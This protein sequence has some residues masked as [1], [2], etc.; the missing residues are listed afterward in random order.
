MAR[1][2]IVNLSSVSN[3]STGL[4]TVA[5]NVVPH[6]N[7]FRPLVLARESQVAGWRLAMPDSTVEGIPD[8]L[9]SDSGRLGHA[10]RLVWVERDLARLVRSTGGMLFSPVPEAPILKPVPSVVMVY[11]FIAMHCFPVVHPLHQYTKHYVPRVIRQARSSVCISSATSRDVVDRVDGHGDLATIT[12]GVDHQRFRPQGLDARKRFLYVGRYKDYKNVDMAVRAFA[13]LRRD[14][15][16]FWLAGPPDPGFARLAETKTVRE[17]QIRY[18]GQPTD[19][20][21]P[22]LM[23]SS[24]GL[25]MV[26]RSEGFGLPVLEAMASGTAVITSN[27]S[28]MPEAGGDAALMVD[29]ADEVATATAMTRLADDHDFRADR[30]SAG[31]RHAARFTWESAGRQLV[32]LIE[33]KIS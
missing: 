13:S 17:G 15:L 7:V 9:S 8:G 10:R 33:H 1:R 30:V 28:A 11:D 31:I 26:S 32:E 6:L 21:L 18:I 16:E 20:E 19:D 25:V 12:L 27:V 29:P 23:E 4:A 24:L 5:R 22:G 2:L 3:G 14:D